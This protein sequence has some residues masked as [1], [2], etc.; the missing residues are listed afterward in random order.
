M[1]NKEI[2]GKTKFLQIKKEIDLILSRSEKHDDI[3]GLANSLHRMVSKIYRGI[4]EESSKPERLD[5]CVQEYLDQL[6][7]KRPSK[8]IP[9]KYK[10]LDY[11]CG[12][13]RKGELVIFG[14]RPGMGKTA[15]LFQLMRDMSV[16]KNHILYFSLDQTKDLISGRILSAESKVPISKIRGWGVDPQDMEQLVAASK[17]IKDQE[18]HI[19]DNV[20]TIVEVRS[21]TEMAMKEGKIDVVIVDYLQLLSGASY[22]YSNRESEVALVSKGLKNMARDLNVCVIVSSQLSRAVETRGGDKRPQLSDLRESGAIE[23]DADKV[24]F[25]YRPAYYDITVDE[26]GNDLRNIMEVIVAKNRNGPMSAF[27]LR[28]NDDLSEIKDLESIEAGTAFTRMNDLE[29]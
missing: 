1:G 22:R 20:S 9:T 8:I 4:S 2:S 17:R 19:I 24:L 3:E 21:K 15:F 10:E 16:N 28:L 11:R 12:G 6:F 23:Q 27:C 14:G 13:L 18:I 5:A 25:L 29:E 26:N 7:N